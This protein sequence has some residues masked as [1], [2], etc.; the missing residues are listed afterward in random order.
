[1]TVKSCAI[2]LVRF[3]KF[4][5]NIPSAMQCMGQACV[6]ITIIYVK[7]Y[8]REQFFST[9]NWLATM[10]SYISGMHSSARRVE[11]PHLNIY[12]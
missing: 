10:K 7:I 8:I 5:N 9:G 11:N 6:T 4:I 12:V 2:V 1:M 3:S